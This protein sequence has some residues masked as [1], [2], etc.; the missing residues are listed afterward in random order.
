MGFIRHDGNFTGEWF[1]GIGNM[2]NQGPPVD[3]PPVLY[4]SQTEYFYLRLK[5][6]QV[7]Y[8]YGYRRVGKAEFAYH[9]S[10]G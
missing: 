4:L 2:G 5:Y 9:Y 1:I 8:S 6:I 3:F 10:I 7:S